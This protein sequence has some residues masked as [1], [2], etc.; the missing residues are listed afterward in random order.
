MMIE[1]LIKD[2]KN[3]PK[4]NIKIANLLQFSQQIGMVHEKL[5]LPEPRKKKTPLWKYEQEVK[6]RHLEKLYFSLD[7]NDTHWIAGLIDF[8]NRTFLFGMSNTYF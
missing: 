8:K 4:S 6:D 7:I 1:E 3:N 2:F 5:A